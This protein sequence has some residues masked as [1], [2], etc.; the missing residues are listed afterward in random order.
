MH[1]PREAHWSAALRIL[2]Y[3]KSYPTKGLAYK[4]YEHVHIFVYSNLGYAG[5]RRNR[6]ST[7]RCCIFIRENLVT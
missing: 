3:I 1:Q 6:K 5:D 2:A 4:K 7:T